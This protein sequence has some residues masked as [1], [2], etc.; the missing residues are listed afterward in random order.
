[1]RRAIVF[2]AVG[3]MVTFGSAASAE[4]APTATPAPSAT[5]TPT[6]TPTVELRATDQRAV[7]ER[8]TGTS[9][10]SGFAF[11][12]ASFF[13][14]GHW[15]H[16][17]VAPCQLKLDPRFTYRVSGE[18]L[19]PTDSFTIPQGR[20]RVR[21]DA[22]MGSSTGRLA[23]ILLTG[24]GAVGATMGAIALGV[25]PILESEDVGSKG[26]R[27]ALVAGGAT[28]LAAGMVSLGVGLYL[29][30]SNGSTVQQEGGAITI[31]RSDVKLTPNGIAF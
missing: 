22:R 30:L 11:S 3:A 4:E 6:P 15:E 14:M 24:A 12:D 16:A 25:S 19:V 27:T 1:M 9:G 28:F 7:I 13:S 5:A 17:C 31:G 2:L 23:G 8:R 10:P 21:L 20:D 29:W 18:G 26:F